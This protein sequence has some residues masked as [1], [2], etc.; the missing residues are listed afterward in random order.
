MGFAATLA[1]SSTRVLTPMCHR[2]SYP[3]RNFKRRYW[4]LTLAFVALTGFTA[5]ACA[6][7]ALLWQD[8]PA[9]IGSDTAV[10]SAPLHEYRALNLNL[11]GLRA[12]LDSAPD[13]HSAGAP[14]ILALPMPDGSAQRFA[15]YRTQVMAP[16]LAAR[17][18]QIRSYVA[19]AVDH[20]EIQARLD[21]SPHG[22][23]AMIRATDG[24]TLLQP[25]VL[26]EGTRYI[27]FR[28]EMLGASSPP[29]RCL[30][31]DNASLAAQLKSATHAG[32]APV[33]QTVTGASVRT[34]RLA[35]AATGEYTLFFGGT[36]ADGM[37]AIVQA[38]N[39]VNGIYLTDFAVQFQLV[40]NNDQLVYMD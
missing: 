16:Q 6:N 24:V 21:D 18:P 15:V 5:A 13:E 27:S 10:L 36:V 31:D 1:A 22:F 28:R 23:S 37:A 17:Y 33:P 11:A 34:Y 26:G 25:V 19:F 3:N 20:Q 35:V 38:I 32:A 30:V 8:R 2:F 29:F 40:N 7:D 4:R 39:R 9:Q 14:A 12:A